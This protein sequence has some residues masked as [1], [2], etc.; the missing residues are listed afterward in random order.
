ML[1]YSLILLLP[2]LALL[3]FKRSKPALQHN[4]FIKVKLVKKINVSPNTSIYRF[5]LTNQQDYLGL[6]TGQHIIIQADIN[7]KQIQRMYT[8]VTS[9]QDKGFFELII[10]VTSQSTSQTYP[11]DNTS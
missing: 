9:D 5:K 4:R 10:K 2:L 8:P 11:L 7:G 6:P 3:A 1:Y